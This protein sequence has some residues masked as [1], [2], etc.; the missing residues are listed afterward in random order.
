MPTWI[1]KP[2]CR[3]GT[4]SRRVITSSRNWKHRLRPYRPRS[5][6]R[7]SGVQPQLFDLAPP[8]VLPH[9]MLDSVSLITP[10]QTEAGIL[11][12]DTELRIQTF[13]DAESAAPRRGCLRSGRAPPC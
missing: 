13:A 4:T 7:L 8:Q 9:S 5:R 12:G 6:T 11:I 1:R 2:P 3:N 10:N